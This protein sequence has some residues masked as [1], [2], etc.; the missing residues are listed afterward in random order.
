MPTNNMSD[1]D[2][3]LLGEPQ[4]HRLVGADELHQEALDACQH[5][6]GEHQR[7]LALEP[8]ADQPTRGAR[9]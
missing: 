2:P 6:V 3:L 5:G 4:S 8:G 1:A 9:R 7:A